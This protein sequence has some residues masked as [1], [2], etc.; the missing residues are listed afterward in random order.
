MMTALV[1]A[2][3]SGYSRLGEVVQLSTKMAKAVLVNKEQVPVLE[4]E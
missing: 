2:L 3:A 1:L 4:K